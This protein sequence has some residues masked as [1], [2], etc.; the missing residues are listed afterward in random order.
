MTSAKPAA[1][2]ASV[3]G[4]RL[5]PATPPSQPLPLGGAQRHGSR[6]APSP[7]P[8]LLHFDASPPGLLRSDQPPTRRVAS[9]AALHLA[10]RPPVAKER[11][12]QCLPALSQRPYVAHRR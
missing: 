4:P 5:A 7:G 12:S 1:K 3:R 2:L 6:P 9:D 8:P 10:R 11:A